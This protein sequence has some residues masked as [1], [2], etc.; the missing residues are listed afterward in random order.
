VPNDLRVNDVLDQA[1]IL[2]RMGV[3]IPDLAPLLYIGKDADARMDSR[4][5]HLG[6][7][8]RGFLVVNPFS[9]WSSKTWPAERY[10]EV[11]RSFA[12]TGAPPVVITGSPAERDDAEKLLRLLPSGSAISLAGEF[13]LAEAMAVYKR[14]AVMLT[15]DSGPMHAAAALGTRVI[16]LFGPTWPERSAPWGKGHVVIQ[17]SRP[18]RHHAYR[19]IDGHAHMLAIDVDTVS[20]ALRKV[21]QSLK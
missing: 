4:L 14:A 5:R 12:Q 2:E 7:P 11:I 19:D 3:A 20:A 6:L 8:G 10:A 16:A 13:G 9:R 15:G 1:A 21:W 17:R 18:E